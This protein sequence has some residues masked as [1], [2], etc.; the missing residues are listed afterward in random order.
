VGWLVGWLE[1]DSTFFP[2][3]YI[4]RNSKIELAQRIIRVKQLLADSRIVAAEEVTVQ[5]P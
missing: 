4:I 5:A 1:K 2:F 3:A